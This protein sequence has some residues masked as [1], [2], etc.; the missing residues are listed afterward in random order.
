MKT[1]SGYQ[2]TSDYST[3]HTDSCENTNTEVDKV[4]IQDNPIIIYVETTQ[5]PRDYIFKVFSQSI[6]VFNTSG[7]MLL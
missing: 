6:T 2:Q 5:Q 3:T 4:T 1:A 7:Q